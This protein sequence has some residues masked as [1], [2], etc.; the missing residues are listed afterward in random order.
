V[1]Y[2]IELK[3]KFTRGAFRKKLEVYAVDER[4]NISKCKNIYV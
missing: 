3:H 2:E 4:I 1:L